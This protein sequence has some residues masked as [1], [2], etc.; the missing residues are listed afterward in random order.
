MSYLNRLK[1]R[2]NKK[3]RIRFLIFCFI[4]L[5]IGYFLITKL[6]H[7]KIN[8][9]VNSNKNNNI[10]PSQIPTASPV[11]ISVLPLNN[12]PLDP[13]I[14]SAL[15][16]TKGSYG[17]AI[18]NLKSN[19]KYYA[20]EHKSYEAGSL[21][22]LWVMAVAFK[23]IQE[24]ILSE[25]EVLSDDV[26]SLN[27]A[28]NI[29]PSQAELTEGIITLSVHDALNQM[30]TISHNY[31]ALLLSKKIKLSSVAV[32]LKDFGFNESSIGTNNGAPASTPNDIALF[33]EKLYK[34]QLA[35]E[36]Y[37]KEMIDL[38]KNQQLN[39][40]LPKYLPQDIDIAHKTGE[41]NSVSHDAG[42]V[43]TP[44]GDYIIAVLSDTDIPSAAEDR[45]AAVSKAVYTYFYDLQ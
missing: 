30:I 26:D 11:P 18:K 8:Q 39:N 32:F 23:Q 13:A 31:A 22:K 7:T 9:P 41:I 1:Y 29:D 24:G 42:I 35:N 38:L 17:I 25:D 37:T 21:Y 15:D 20:N 44:K 14:R 28:F 5:T 33:F 19:E 45:I 12:S 2:R 3:R 4:F 27:K 16:G 34:N 10:T 6:V 40:K 43:Y 36:Q